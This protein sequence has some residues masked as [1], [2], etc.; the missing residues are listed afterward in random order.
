MKI[1]RDKSS[2]KIAP[3]ENTSEALLYFLLTSISIGVYPKVPRKNSEY[4]V[5]PISWKQRMIYY[6]LDHNA[7]IILSDKINSLILL[8]LAEFV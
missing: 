6:L 4:S 8:Y 5:A 1:F 7:G 2:T 3:I